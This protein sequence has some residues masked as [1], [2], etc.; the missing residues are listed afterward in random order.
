LLWRSAGQCRPSR[1]SS[2]KPMRI[3]AGRCSTEVFGWGSIEQGLSRPFVELPC[4]GAELGLA[5]QGEIR[6][7]REILAQ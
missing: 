6:A 3:S 1:G 5:L 4:Y 7:A 2:R